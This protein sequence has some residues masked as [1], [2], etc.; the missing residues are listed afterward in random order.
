M[1]SQSK[2]SK[3]RARAAAAKKR[4]T[5]S[6]R[7]KRTPATSSQKKRPRQS[8]TDEASSDHEEHDQSA[9]EADGDDEDSS[10]DRGAGSEENK[11]GGLEWRWNGKSTLRNDTGNRHYDEAERFKRLPN[12]QEAFDADEDENITLRVGDSVAVHTAT[13][14]RT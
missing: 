1:G 2:S 8:R 11:E 10:D 12:G 13:G 9:D 3:K 7:T 5:A 4:K 14:V 6:K